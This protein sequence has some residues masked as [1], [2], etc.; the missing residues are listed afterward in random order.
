MQIAGAMA[1]KKFSLDA[2]QG[3]AEQVAESIGECC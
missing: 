2:I 3:V 1:E